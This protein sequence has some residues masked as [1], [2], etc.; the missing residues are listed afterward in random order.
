M[1]S[2]QKESRSRGC[3]GLCGG[4]ECSEFL[5][6]G[7]IP[8]AFIFSFPAALF[9]FSLTYYLKIRY[10]RKAL[11]NKNS[12]QKFVTYL[13]TMILIAYVP[14]YLQLVGAVPGHFDM[15][16]VVTAGFAALLALYIH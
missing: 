3:K 16:D 8:H 1:D 9:A 2:V 5:A 4:G 12:L 10:M 13:I 6:N 15:T 7:A 14:E 11:A